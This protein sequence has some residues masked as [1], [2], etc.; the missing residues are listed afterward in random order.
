MVVLK[1][2]DLTEEEAL[3]IKEQI[4]DA[5]KL[6]MYLN[7]DSEAACPFALCV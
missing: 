5:S 6:G 4:K 2:G 3:K 7:T 1:K